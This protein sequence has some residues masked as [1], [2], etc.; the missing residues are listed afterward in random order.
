MHISAKGYVN[1]CHEKG[2]LN[3]ACL[4]ADRR[5]NRRFLDVVQ[6][7]QYHSW[8]LWCNRMCYKGIQWTYLITEYADDAAGFIDKKFLEIADDFSVYDTI[9]STVGQPL[10]H[11]MRMFTGYI[12]EGN[13]R[14]SDVQT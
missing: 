14:K 10:V 7:S 1:S 6:L 13:N 3:R 5:S 4:K 11:G 2:T 12:G 9:F 8:L